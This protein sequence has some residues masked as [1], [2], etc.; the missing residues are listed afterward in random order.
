MS[1]SDGPIR[2]TKGPDGEPLFT[3]APPVNTLNEFVLMAG[4]NLP[5]HTTTLAGRGKFVASGAQRPPQFRTKQEVY[6]F[7]AWALLMADA[8]SLPDEPGEH[9]LEEVMEA[10]RNV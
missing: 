3:Q 5:N 1:R 7:C 10:C 8:H 6:R 9:T 2:E 4:E